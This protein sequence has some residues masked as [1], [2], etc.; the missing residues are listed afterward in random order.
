MRVKRCVYK[1]CRS[2]SRYY[3]KDYMSGVVFLPFPKPKT[4]LAKCKKWIEWLDRP[5]YPIER[6]GYNTYIC[7]KHFVGGIGPTEQFPNPIHSQTGYVSILKQSFIPGTGMANFSGQFTLNGNSLKTG[8]ISQQKPFIEVASVSAFDKSLVKSENDR[9][10]NTCS[11]SDKLP[12]ICSGN[13]HKTESYSGNDQQADSSSGN[14]QQ[15]DSSYENV[16]QVESCSANDQ[17]ADNCSGND[18]LL[19]SSFKEIS[20]NQ[21][22]N[23]TSV[24]Q[25]LELDGITSLKR[26]R[27]DLSY[28]VNNSGNN[29]PSG[30]EQNLQAIFMN[31]SPWKNWSITFYN[32]IVIVRMVK[33]DNGLFMMGLSIAKDF[34]VQYEALNKKIT[35]DAFLRK[36]PTTISSQNALIMVMKQLE[37]F[38]ICPGNF[39]SRFLEIYRSRSSPV[40]FECNVTGGVHSYNCALV[41]TDKIKHRCIYCRKQR[42]NFRV[43]LTKRKYQA[44]PSR[45]HLKSLTKTELIARLKASVQAGCKLTAKVKKLEKMMCYRNRL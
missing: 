15:V 11:G 32:N 44:L 1:T 20:P 17:R 33:E 34:S 37:E 6:V 45:P 26:D 18:A 2:D 3:H 24:E 41:V 28:V 36:M 7:S 35:D 21:C 30:M 42:L 14:D 9:S 38:K 12:N 10:P 29:T 5:D 31:L 19:D 8:C 25:Y 40:G 43:T 27:E 16:Q 13:D 4:N 23:D 39:E 22:S